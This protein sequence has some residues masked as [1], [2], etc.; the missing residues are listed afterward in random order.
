MTALINFNPIN[1]HS[2]YFSHLL[3]I[4][5]EKIIQLDTKTREPIDEI[6]LY[7]GQNVSCLNYSL[8]GKLL[9][10]ATT[11]G[12]IYCRSFPEDQAQPKAE[13]I[14]GCSKKSINFLVFSKD[15]S[16]LAFADQ[17]F[18]VG[19]LEVETMTIK[20]RLKVHAKL[21]TKLVFD[22]HNDLFRN[23]T[24]IRP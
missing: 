23:M 21:I 13:P 8:S 17:Y 14:Q 7:D 2:F 4:G 9:A 15:E 1:T 11:E 5:H 18:C 16:L 20:S 19:L 24:K 3:T 10:F 22:P 12:F 6:G